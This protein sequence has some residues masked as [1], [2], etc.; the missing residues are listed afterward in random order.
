MVS[1]PSESGGSSF[2]T[3]FSQEREAT[4][5][6]RE[7]TTVAES[8]ARESDRINVLGDFCEDVEDFE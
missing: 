2:Y 5:S 6:M 7:T 8:S 3:S 4:S 1:A